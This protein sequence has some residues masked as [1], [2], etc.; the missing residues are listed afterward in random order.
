MGRFVLA[1]A[2]QA[3]KDYDVLKSAIRA[4]TIE[5]LMDR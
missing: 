1:Y 2:D 4:G 5:V 3:E